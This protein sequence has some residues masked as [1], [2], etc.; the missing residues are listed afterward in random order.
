MFRQPILPMTL[1]LLAGLT[2]FEA[3]PSASR[4]A[5]FESVEAMKAAYQQLRSYTDSGTV[6][7]ESQ[8]P[9]GSLEAERYAF[10]TAFIAPRQFLLAFRPIQASA[11]GEFVVWS[12]G[13]VWETWWSVTGVHQPYPPGQGVS[14]LASGMLPTFGATATLPSLVFPAAEI[15]S[16]ITDLTVADVRTDSLDGRQVHLVR[17]TEKAHFGAERPVTLWIDARTNLLLKLVEDTPAGAIAGVVDRV[18]TIYKPVVN[19]AID[20]TRFAFVPPRPR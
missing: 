12:R 13:E 19:P 14:A 20:A 17:G 15:H 2:A 5:V 10:E 3:T 8:A 11:G 9:G 7:V 16:A 18:T 6:V 1:A 4:G